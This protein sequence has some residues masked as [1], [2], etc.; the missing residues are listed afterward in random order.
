MEI[1]LIIFLVLYLVGLFVFLVWS[2]FHLYHMIRFG[3]FDFTGK[4]NTLVFI[5]L[6][7]IILVLTLLFLREIP[8][9]TS[10]SVFD[11]R[12]LRDNIDMFDRL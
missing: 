5:V 10:A 3:M 12:S 4:L 2:A 1:P 9:T 11:V 8:W 7:I 6:T